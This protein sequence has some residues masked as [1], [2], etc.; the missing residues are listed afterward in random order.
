MALF[1]KSNISKFQLS[2]V[3][4]IALQDYDQNGLTDLQLGQDVGGED[5]DVLGGHAAVD[6][7]QELPCPDGVC[8]RPQFWSLH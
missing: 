7:L 4:K 8:H 1:A 2:I 6:L 5:E 3:W